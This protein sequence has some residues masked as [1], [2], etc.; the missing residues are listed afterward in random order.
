[1]TGFS[2]NIK[3][4]KQSGHEKSGK[5]NFKKLFTEKR[6]NIPPKGSH[7]VPEAFLI[8]RARE[9]MSMKLEGKTYKQIQVF[10]LKKYNYGSST[11]ES[12]ILMMYQEIKRL[13][14]E[15]IED[16]IVDHYNK[17]EF[18]YDKA[19]GIDN[20]DLMIKILESKEKLLNLVQ[21]QPSIVLNEFFK[22][23]DQNSCHYNLDL[24]SQSQ[25]SRLITLL[26]KAIP[27]IVSI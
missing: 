1:M 16:L 15:R 25:R 3:K 13:A 5:N 20:Q 2:S 8:E 23:K 19:R 10:L 22:T 14:A 12:I 24:L 9:V 4:L 7:V 17:Y 27:E 26:N 18:L 21:D 11:I 6:N